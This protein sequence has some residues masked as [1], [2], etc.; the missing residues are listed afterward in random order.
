L[1]QVSFCFNDVDF[2]GGKGKGGCGEPAGNRLAKSKGG[3][4]NPTYANQPP[5]SA[6]QDAACSSGNRAVTCRRAP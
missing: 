4:G 5:R 2:L 3:K 1:E 6:T